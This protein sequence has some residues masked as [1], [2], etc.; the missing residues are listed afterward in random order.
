MSKKS[1][2][3]PKPV[4][5]ATSKMLGKAKD[6]VKRKAKGGHLC[7]YCRKNEASGWCNR[8]HMC[9]S[10]LSGNRKAGGGKS[11]E[12]CSRPRSI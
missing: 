1:S 11:Y 3:I 12:P 8:M 5:R 6:A 4:K 9:S 2:I 10:C 7:Q